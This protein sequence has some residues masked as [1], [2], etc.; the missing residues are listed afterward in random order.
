[1]AP[2]VVAILLRL[3]F[4]KNRLTGYL[5]TLATTWFVVN[6][7]IAPYSVRMTQDLRQIFH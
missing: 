6:V 3:V 7:L 4:G 1:M 5:I 2:F